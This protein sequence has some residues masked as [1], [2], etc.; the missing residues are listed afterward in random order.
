LRLAPHVI[1]AK[2]GTQNSTCTIWASAC[3]GMT[4]GTQI[5]TSPINIDADPQFG[6]HCR[7]AVVAL[8]RRLTQLK[9]CK[10]RCTS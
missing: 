7:N 9:T 10:W 8:L 2:A 4:D 1:L 6:T 3:A 5:S